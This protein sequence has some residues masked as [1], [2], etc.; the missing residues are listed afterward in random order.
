MLFKRLKLKEDDRNLE[1]Y[2]YNEK[3]GSRKQIGTAELGRT[4]SRS[5]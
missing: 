5:I 1:I 2:I 3:T 4:I